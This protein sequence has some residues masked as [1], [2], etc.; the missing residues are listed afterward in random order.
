[1][2]CFINFFQVEDLYYYQFT[3]GVLWSL[4]HSIPVNFN[5]ALLENFQGQ[6]EVRGIGMSQY[7]GLGACRVAVRGALLLF[8][9]VG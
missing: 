2:V 6:Y 3:Q 8:I 9:V 5:E 4:F 7:R 1:M